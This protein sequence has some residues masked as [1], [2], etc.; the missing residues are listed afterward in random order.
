LT[1]NGQPTTANQQQMRETRT[2]R[3]VNCQLSTVNY[4]FPRATQFFYT[5]CEKLK[6]PGDKFGNIF[7]KSY[8]TD[9]GGCSATAI[10]FKKG[11]M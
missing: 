1:A 4:F 10:S 9:Y 7:A 8:D 6:G 2:S 11:T 5:Y 3:A